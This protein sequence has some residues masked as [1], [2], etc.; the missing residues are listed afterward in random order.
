MV[1]DDLGTA[2]IVYETPDGT[3]ERT[4]QNE[5]IAY[6]QD[7]WIVKTDEDGD[8]HDVVRRIPLQRVHYVERSVDEFEEE[9]Q[10]LRNQVESFA[11]DVRSRLLGGRE[12]SEE[13]PH[14]IDVD[15]ES[16][17]RR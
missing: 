2:T 1:D 17:D 8:D 7:H 12:R 5:H 9:V 16:D 4:V 15:S 13:E 11:E 6:F 14:H 3:V 10:T